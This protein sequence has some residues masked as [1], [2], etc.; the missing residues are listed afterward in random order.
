MIRVLTVA[1]AQELERE[2]EARGTSIE[3]LMERAGHAVA[4]AAVDVA[5]GAYGRRAAVVCGKGNNGGDGLVAARYLARW[6]MRPEVLLVPAPEDLPEPAATNLRRLDGAGVRW[7]RWTAEGAERL[8]ARADVAVDALFGIRFSGTPRDPYPAAIGLFEAHDVPAV[9]V[10]IASGVEGDTGA[11][12]GPS[13]LADVT[14]TFGAPKVGNVLPPGVHRG[15]RVMVA[16]IGFPRDGGS[17]WAAA[18]LEPGHVPLPPPRHPQAHKREAVVLVVAGSRRMTGAPRLVAEGAY[19]A[20]AGLV[21]L[22]VPEGILPVVQR[23]IAEATFLPLP[24]GPEGAV[25]EAAWKELEDRLDGFH[26]V[27]VGPGL[28]T[29]GEAPAFVRRLVRGSERPLV[30]DAD[31]LN[32]FRGDA[33]AVADRRAGAVLTPHEGEMGRLLSRSSGRVGE[34]RLGAAREAAAAAGAVVLLK[35]SRIVVVEPGG[36]AV[37]NPIGSPALATAG[38][39]DVLTGMI[40]AFLASGAEP[41]DAASG[42]AYILEVAGAICEERTGQGTVARDVARTLAEAIRL[43]REGGV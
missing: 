43:E 13:I 15:G 22:A 34:D 39:G 25:S 20:G 5:G 29:D 10:D 40:A 16:D 36:R 35:G 1:E 23:E 21:T 14:V 4:R 32:A 6:G 28:S 9:S 12:R 19:R 42:G 31:A 11:V 41:P 7:R 27:A 26:A 17:P 24:E 38:T 33:G 37:I 8:F 3:T 2:A 30:V 18:L